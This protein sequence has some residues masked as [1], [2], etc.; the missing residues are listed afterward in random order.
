[1]LTALPAGKVR[2]P[3]C[4][5]RVRK[6]CANRRAASI[7]L[8]GTDHG[9]GFTLLELLVVL[10]IAGMLLALAPIAFQRLK[11]S[12]DYRDTIRTVAADLAAA[13]HAAAST[14]R[15]VAFSV[16]LAR[17]SYGVEGKATRELPAGVQ[18]RATVAD[19]EVEND[20]ARIRFYPGGSSTGG[21]I[22]IVRA[23][24]VGVRLRTDW[25]DGR[26]AIEEL[27]Q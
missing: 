4:A 13:R 3:T 5:T 10:G 21:T 23:T 7:G 2:T 17:R 16:D 8:R 27:P 12:S 11:E 18:V 14:G 6:R 20:V 22:E 25:L 19:V 15:G 26:S 1:V 24:G 9:R